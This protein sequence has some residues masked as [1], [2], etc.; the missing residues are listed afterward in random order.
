[1]GK[2]KDLIKAVLVLSALALIA[3]VLLGLFY[4]I[5]Y[6]SAEELQ[7]RTVKKLN[8]FYPGDNYEIVEFVS[9]DSDLNANIDYFFYDNSSNVYAIVARGVKGYGGVVP[10]YVII[11]DNAIIA[12]Q[13]G[14]ISETPGVSDAA[15]SD[16]HL[17]K[18][19]KDIDKLDFTSVD[20]ATGATYSSGA[21]LSSV[22]NAVKFYKEYINS[23]S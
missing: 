2:H 14:S 12:L 8:E 11:K 15:F 23:I 19:M 10:M 5:T 13:E 21:I 7:Q 18:F 22:E 9:A 3:G 4:Q 16:G 17:N 20:A 6:I 1:M